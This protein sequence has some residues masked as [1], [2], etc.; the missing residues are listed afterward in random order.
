MDIKQAVDA[1]AAVTLGKGMVMRD[2]TQ[3]C[4][5]MRQLGTGQTLTVLL[6][7][8]V[9]KLVHENAKGVSSGAAADELGAIMNWLICN[10]LDAETLMATQLMVQS[11]HNASRRYALQTLLHASEA[12]VPSEAA[13]DKISPSLMS[14]SSPS[15]V[16]LQVPEWSS[17]DVDAPAAVAV[18]EAGGAKEFL[19]SPLFPAAP[20]LQEV[21]DEE[22]PNLNT[23]LEQVMAELKL[24]REGDAEQEAEGLALTY[25]HIKSPRD[26]VMALVHNAFAPPPSKR[27]FGY[28]ED[29]YQLVQ[30]SITY[31]DLLGSSSTS[32]FDPDEGETLDQVSKDE[33]E[34]MYRA[35]EFIDK[36]FLPVY[37]GVEM[38]VFCGSAFSMAAEI[39]AKWA[40]VK[41][42]DD[43]DGKAE[44]LADGI[45]G[46]G[47]KYP[48]EAG[49]HKLAAVLSE[50]VYQQLFQ[51]ESK[52][53]LSPHGFTLR[54]CIKPALSQP[55]R[56]V[57]CV[58]GSLASYDQLAALF[59][60][61]IKSLHNVGAD[62]DVPQHVD[63]LTAW[64]QEERHIFFL[65]ISRFPAK[66][67]AEPN[68]AT[69][70]SG[71][72]RVSASPGKGAKI[73]PAPPASPLES[74]GLESRRF[75]TRRSP[76]KPS[77]PETAGGLQ[78]RLDSHDPDQL[79]IF[80]NSTVSAIRFTCTR[81]LGPLPARQGDRATSY[82]FLP[83][84]TSKDRA[85]VSQAFD[86]ALTMIVKGIAHSKGSKGTADSKVSKG[87]YPQSSSD[88]DDEELIASRIFRGGEYRD[89]S[90]I[91]PIM[92]EELIAAGAL[93]K[94][95]AAGSL[96]HDALG[97][98]LD[99]PEHR[100]LF[101][102]SDRDRTLLIW[103][104]ESEHMR[105]AIEYK[106]CDV[107][108]A[109]R[110]YATCCRR[111]RKALKVLQHD[112]AQ[113]ERLGFVGFDPQHI[114]TGFEGSVRIRLDYADGDDVTAVAGGT[115]EVAVAAAAGVA[116]KPV[117]ETR[118][119]ICKE[120]GLKLS[121]TTADQ[122]S[123]TWFDLTTTTCIGKGEVTLVRDLVAGAAR[124][125]ERDRRLLQE[126]KSK[127]VDA[128]LKAKG[129]RQAREEL[130]R[131]RF[132]KQAGLPVDLPL[133]LLPH[134]VLQ[135]CV[136]MFREQLKESLLVPCKLGG[137][138][139]VTTLVTKVVDSFWMVTLTFPSDDNGII[140]VREI[141]NELA[142]GKLLL[143]PSQ[144][145]SAGANG[146]EDTG[147][148]DASL[149]TEMVQE[150]EQQQQV[151]KVEVNIDFGPF[152]D[153][154][155]DEITYWK[156]SLLFE[157]GGHLPKDKLMPLSRMK[158]HPIACKLFGAET[159]SLRFSV[160]PQ[161][162]NHDGPAA[163]AAAAAAV[164][165]QLRLLP[166][167]SLTTAELGVA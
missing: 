3:A 134:E 85:I 7:P 111:L 16:A 110:A 51:L 53:P 141:R 148:D 68:H 156:P 81:S 129:L 147:G 26:A 86:D 74:P 79:P 66:S 124:L 8:E 157:P 18:G 63:S 151:Q 96:A 31:T 164:L 105:L 113:H 34:R 52:T 6:V 122:S 100:G 57:G 20:P 46:D 59:N 133:P 121:E 146:D 78:T 43:D 19:R 29:G 80:T 60:P 47:D 24:K 123:G 50:E 115:S 98:D 126:A 35:M 56:A 71:R 61:L 160:R 21:L 65:P 13:A 120:F 109:F 89:L 62:E 76:S 116:A 97:G 138:S 153:R 145:K 39:T 33:L 166:R 158:M 152:D 91:D 159:S 154:I 87:D 137:G 112:F 163:A 140:A 143:P 77:R 88:V 106:G 28:I 114:G 165:S 101:R 2:H 167:L 84:S 118:L 107:Q 83:A 150:Q 82:P 11:V 117:A 64:S 90:S 142:K 130:Q 73:T 44:A 27:K 38:D 30:Y 149:N 99:W 58:A 93:F 22:L 42:G 108:S 4:W 36:R 32:L 135:G 127:S 1:H 103:V 162:P 55:G 139:E 40:S 14:P 102:N 69:S 15:K 95:P 119:S 72:P 131:Q 75:S 10:S 67:V 41:G 54:K 161:A 25:K 92:A 9:D 48:L 49:K 45:A 155:I 23:L 125:I 37:F 128:L 17:A 132:E 104:N 94:E 70:P 5:R 136:R 144:S 12:P